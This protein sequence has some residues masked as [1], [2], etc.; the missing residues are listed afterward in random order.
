MP[1]TQ[2]EREFD[3]A[4]HVADMDESAGLAAGSVYH[5]SKVLDQHLFAYYAK[6]DELR[7]TDGALFSAILYWLVYVDNARP[8]HVVGGGGVVGC[9]GG[10]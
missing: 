7:I 8:I 10:G 1:A 4:N 5:M 3:A 9:W 2:H 6:N